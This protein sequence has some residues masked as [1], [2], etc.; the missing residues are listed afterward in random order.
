MLYGKQI[1]DFCQDFWD[2]VFF[3]DRFFGDFW[4]IS[5]VMLGGSFFGFYIIFNIVLGD[6]WR[7]FSGIFLNSIFLD[8]IFL[9]S[10][11]FP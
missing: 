5:G 11:F 4:R 1:P 10:I 9:D 7:I 6:F 2:L 8:S 3:L